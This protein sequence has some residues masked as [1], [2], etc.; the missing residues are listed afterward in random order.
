MP[1][2]VEQILDSC[3]NEWHLIIAYMFMIA[4]S[5]LIIIAQSATVIYNKGKPV[6]E[7]MPAAWKR[8]GQS[9][10][11]HVNES[12]FRDNAAIF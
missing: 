8:E 3:K 4:F 9:P 12:I 2:I 1:E 7:T 10:H 11:D 5:L 6:L